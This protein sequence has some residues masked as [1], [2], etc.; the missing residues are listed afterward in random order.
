[1][2]LYQYQY[3]IKNV[4]ITT[5]KN[6]NIFDGAV[7]YLF[8]QHDYLKRRM[9]IIR[10]TIE[11]DKD[12]IASIYKN[13][14]TAV[15]K[16]EVFEQQLDADSKIINTSLF[17]KH[18]FS[19]IPAKNQNQYITSSDS[20]TEAS[21]DTMQTLQLFEAYL[22]DMTAVAWF[23]KQLDNIFEKAAKPAALQALFQI[24]DV[25]NGILIATPPQDNKI[26]NYMILPLGDLIGNIDV[27]NKTYGIYDSYPIIY[28][29]LQYLYCINRMNPNIVLPSATDFGNITFILK[30]PTTP[31]QQISGSCT[32]VAT[33]TH[34]INLREEPKIN[35]YTN[36]I[37]STKF[38]TIGSIDVDGKFVKTTLDNDA[39]TLKYVFEQNAMTV[40]QIV[41]ENMN[42]PTIVMAVN[43][44]A[45]SMLKPYKNITFDVDTQYTNLGL[46]GHI[47][48]LNA[49]NL[50]I[51]REGTGENAVYIHDVIISI[52]QPKIDN[53]K[54]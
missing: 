46:E 10:L 17:L 16:L 45:A 14:D 19:I 44:I 24:R 32:D 23:S 12:V 9:P 15:I 36:M 43:S 20:T 33:K 28:Y 48:R 39:T 31:E 11:L 50:S 29:D 53:T 4:T 27:L 7:N 41:N 35:D 5:D 3:A 38:S 25:P 8:I 18:T 2:E 40:D 21:M 1:M 22:M 51:T 52:T 6:Y 13:K 54:S 34:Y 47:Y 49:W 30:N 37:T 42:G 26:I